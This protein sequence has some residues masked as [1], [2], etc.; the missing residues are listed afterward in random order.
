M[1]AEA[2]TYAIATYS[3]IDALSA[4]DKTAFFNAVIETSQATLRLSLDETKT[5]VKWPNGDPNPCTAYGITHTTYTYAQ[6]LEELQGP[7]WNPDY[8][9]SSSSA[10]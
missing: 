10:G 9:G 2:R 5:I 3:E 8:V 1:S 6:I 7:D 4:E